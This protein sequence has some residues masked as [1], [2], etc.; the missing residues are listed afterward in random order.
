MRV[1]INPAICQGHGMCLLSCSEVFALNDED[2]HAYLLAE[3]VPKGLE[4][5]VLN[6]QA[7]C[8]EQAIEVG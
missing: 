3:E 8:P 1:R 5:A 6:A 7:S 4:E 2:G